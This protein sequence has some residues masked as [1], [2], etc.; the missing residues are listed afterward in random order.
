[1]SIKNLRLLA[2][3]YFIGQIDRDTYL[4]ARHHLIDDIVAGDV[5]LPDDEDPTSITESAITETATTQTARTTRTEPHR[6]E[7]APPPIKDNTPLIIGGVVVVSLVLV[8]S[9]ASFFLAGEDEVPTR[10]NPTQTTAL[11]SPVN[12]E[13]PAPTL[14]ET[15]IASSDWSASALQTTIEEW[16]T[17]SDEE[18]SG[19]SDTL[20]FRQ[21]EDSIYTQILETRALMDIGDVEESVSHREQLLGFA[22]GLGSS[23]QRF[24]LAESTLQQDREASQVQSSSA[25]VANDMPI[26]DKPEQLAN[27]DQT[28]SALTEELLQSSTDDTQQASADDTNAVTPAA[29]APQETAVEASVVEPP[30]AVETPALPDTSQADTSVSQA[31][32]KES[33]AP[34]KLAENSPA[35][36]TTPALTASKTERPRG[37]REALIKSRKPYCRDYLSNTV[38]G[39]VMVVLKGGNFTMGGTKQEE[40]PTASIHIDYNFALS[41]HEITSKEFKLFCTQTKREC[42]KQP[43]SGED[44]PVVNVSWEDALAYTQWLSKN[45]GQHYRLPTE[46][47][48]EFAARSGTTGPY[49]TGDE[50]LPSY[51]RFSYTAAVDSPLP[52]SDRTIN[53]NKFRLY[54]MLGNVQEWVMDNWQASHV[55]LPADGSAFSAGDEQLKVLRGGSYADSSDDLRSASRRYGQRSSG[56]NTTGFR[57]ALVFGAESAAHAYDANLEWLKAQDSSQ[58][59][60]Q[61][62]AVKSITNVK[63]LLDKHPALPIRI[64]PVADDRFGYRILYGVYASE[65]DAEQAFSELP[66]DISGQAGKAVV[67]RVAELL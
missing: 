27:T 55:G 24:S 49:P 17:L 22:R 28:I 52:K 54:H 6:T 35:A 63:K 53:R 20:A 47:E 48:W 9:A 43:W 41:M 11:I 26:V 40:S 59:T 2:K 31:P 57:V 62:F 56:D 42:P 46:A 19:L 67:K 34:T 18:R 45:S 8:V 51:A 3:Q 14:L 33:S 21:L 61:L 23:D 12:E 4:D 38:K 64:V 60:L 44:Y 16:N 37:C 25:E 50:I 32:A 66:L 13:A 39:P 29:I 10:T 7:P 65:A 5:L 30:V 36:V 58:Y 1:M 15:F